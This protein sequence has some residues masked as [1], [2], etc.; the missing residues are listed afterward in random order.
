MLVQ[1]ANDVAANP[2]AP[3]ALSGLAARY[4]QF[5]NTY[6]DLRV[7]YS[8]LREN[9]TTA[10]ASLQRI[11]KFLPGVDATDPPGILPAIDQKLQAIDDAL[12]TA[13]PQPG[14]PTAAAAT[15]IA[16]SATAIQGFI[17]DLSTSVRSLKD[18]LT[19]LQTRA[20]ST[21]DTIQTVILGLTIAV[22]V[23]FVWVLILNV[24]L[25]Q[26]G[27][28]WKR[29]RSSRTAAAAGSGTTSDTSGPA[30]EAPSAT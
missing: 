19:S 25:W 5:A 2:S 14:E 29:E 18:Q 20:T 10:A 9:V 3:D 28:V 15:A 4:A 21:L 30:A 12:T 24:A 11:A 13:L 8:D 7:R 27:R 26:L 6:Q 23:L 22:S 16:T 1:N 17:S